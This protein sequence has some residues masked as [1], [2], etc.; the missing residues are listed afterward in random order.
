MSR[1][2]LKGAHPNNEKEMYYKDKVRNKLT[3]N[4][5]FE[6]ES[7]RMI[8]NE[9]KGMR[10]EEISDQETIPPSTT[11]DIST[12]NCI[13]LTIES[14]VFKAQKVW[15]VT[16]ERKIGCELVTVDSPDNPH[17]VHI[18]TTYITIFDEKS[19]Q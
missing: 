8:S 5:V 2:I 11:A 18:G 7:D 17:K 14:L 16:I 15:S 6:V 12:C 13:E 3:T 1:E 10:K 4:G 9:T 19:T